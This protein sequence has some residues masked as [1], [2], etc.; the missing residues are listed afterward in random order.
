[1]RLPFCRVS[2]SFASLTARRKRRDEK[3]GEREKG[4]QTN[5]RP[6]TGQPWTALS[7][8]CPFYLLHSIPLQF[9]LFCPFSFYLH[10]ILFY[11]IQFY[12]IR[13]PP[14]CHCKRDAKEGPND[15]QHVSVEQRATC[16]SWRQRSGARELPAQSGLPTSV[17]RRE[18]EG[19]ASGAHPRGLSVGSSLSVAHKAGAKRG[20]KFA[21]HSTKY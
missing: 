6:Q 8:C 10:C 12:S 20:A 7:P 14:C 15:R 2:D 19:S 5:T 21:E 16:A 18:R 1:M 11:S 3:K 13:A 17:E 9:I 4:P